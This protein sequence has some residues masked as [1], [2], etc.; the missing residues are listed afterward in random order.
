MANENE[1]NSDELAYDLRQRYAKEVADNMEHINLQRKQR[2]WSEYFDAIEDLYIVT[3]FKWKPE[4]KE[5][6]YENYREVVSKL[7][8]EYPNTWISKDD[9]SNAVHLIKSAL[10]Q[11][12][13]HVYFKM[14]EAN[15]F[16]SKYADDDD[17]L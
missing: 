9:D 2:L 11:L 17:E 1:T 15:M 8:N 16:G 10:R 5:K 14:N 4:D 6:N 7:A 3:N 13:M 12:E